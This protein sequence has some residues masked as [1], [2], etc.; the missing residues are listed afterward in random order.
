MQISVFI[1]ERLKIGH[2]Q[3]LKFLHKNYQQEQRKT[4]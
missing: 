2:M 4:L 1:M 3:F